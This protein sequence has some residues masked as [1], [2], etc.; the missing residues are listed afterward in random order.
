VFNQLE[1]EALDRRHFGQAV[2]CRDLNLLREGKL[3]R[4]FA[5]SLTDLDEGGLVHGHFR[6]EI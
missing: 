5:D 3:A 2:T 1:E 4:V 6:N